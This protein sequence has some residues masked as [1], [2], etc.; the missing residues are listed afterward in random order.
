M[1]HINNSIVFLY[2]KDHGGFGDFIKSLKMYIN[3]SIKINNKICIH[4]E[5]TSIKD[6]IIIKD[7][8][9]YKNNK[10]NVH[11]LK[12]PT[13]IANDKSW[14]TMNPTIC[15]ISLL[16]YISF[17]DVIYKRYEETMKNIKLYNCIHIRRGDKY[18]NKSFPG[19]NDDR[20]KGKDIDS[21]MGNIIKK[22]GDIP[23]ILVSDNINIKKYISEKYK[24]IVSNIN[25]VHLDSQYSK[26]IT[27]KNLDIID[28][29]TE[30]LILCKANTI[31]SIGLSGFSY[32]ASWFYKNKILFY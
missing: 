4:I 24:V 8:Y 16:D 21:I 1:N 22:N 30:Y 14:T 10:T 23:L 17:N 7:K 13:I 32:T 27:H 25:I 12:T 15:E 3:Y 26:N 19:R 31:H 29:L 6:M 2:G 11:F 9:K 5:N 28:N 18:G 20:C